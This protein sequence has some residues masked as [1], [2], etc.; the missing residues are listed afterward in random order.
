MLSGE[1]FL[2]TGATGRLGCAVV[3]R[4]EDLGA[5][6]L[7]LVCEGY[8]VEPKRVRWEAKTEPIL[9]REVV[10]LKEL[11][12]FSY[13][14]NLHWQVNRDLPFSDQVLYEFEMNIHQFAF[15]WDW[16]SSQEL[17][18][19]VNIS[20]IKIFSSLNQNP[21]SADTEPYPLTPYGIAKLTAEKFFDAHFYKLFPVIHLRLCSVASRGENPSQLMSQLRESAFENRYIQINHGHLVYLM[22]IDEAVDLIINAALKGEKRRYIL[23]T[24]GR[25]VGDIVRKYEEVLGKKLN[26]Q[27]VDLDPGV[28]D[29]IFISNIKELSD[30]WTRSTSVEAMVKKFVFSR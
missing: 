7:P 30:S 10:S 24:E 2:V 27:Y 22:D 23:T 20:S 17:K 26:G 6:T 25:R 21:I 12:A 9:L 4:L 19:F 16:L 11:P 13:V 3:T 28:E 14:I 29:Q 5:T 8:P 18:R 1:A 15:L